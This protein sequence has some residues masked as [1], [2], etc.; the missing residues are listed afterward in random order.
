MYKK[1]I[2]SLIMVF[3][4]SLQASQPFVASDHKGDFLIAPL[5]VAKSN[6]CSKVNLM[7]TNETKTIFLKLSIKESIQANEVSL[8]IFLKGGDTWSGV[9][10]QKNDGVYITS[11]DDSNHPAILSKLKNGINISKIS[12]ANGDKNSNFTKGYLEVYPIA[13]LN[14]SSKNTT[15]AALVKKWDRLVANEVISHISK[16]GVGGYALTG[17][18]NILYK[19]ITTSSLDMIA[20][21]GAHDQQ[22]YGNI[23]SYG[24]DSYADLLLG[25]KKTKQISK[26]FKYKKIIINYDNFGKNQYITLTNLFNNDSKQLRSFRIKIVNSNNQVSISKKISQ[27]FMI[28]GA[29]A[30]IS[31]E[32]LISYT[33]D[34]NKFKEGYIEIYSII[35]KQNLPSKYSIIS[36]TIPIISRNL[37]L[38]QKEII[39]DLKYSPF[40]KK[41]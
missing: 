6:I 22:F 33:E 1:M 18:I 41:F 20:I 12:K 31:L 27:K 10:C 36:S 14:V 34:V 40:S 32:K 7:N 19:N 37:K 2:L 30:T 29:V 35:N 9:L 11:S 17:N 3:Y 8:P 21:K 4:V 13:Q 5:Y 28:S 38:N 25:K 16:K 26:L 23:L 39:V 24:T 15:P